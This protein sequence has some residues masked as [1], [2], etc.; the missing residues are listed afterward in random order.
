MKQTIEINGQPWA[1]GF[2]FKAIRNFETLSGKSITHCTSTWD[3]V[4]FFYSTLT[5][6]NKDFPL[7]FEQFTDYMDE[8]PMLLAEF[9]T[10]DL[11]PE[12]NIQNPESN[13][14]HPDQKKN[15][16]GLWML[17]GLLF[18]SPVLLP[19]ISGITWIWLSLKL[20][21]KFIAKIGKKRGS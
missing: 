20:S 11:N 19:I 6:L 10:S 7:D 14:Q 9:T 3:N 21:L 17:T 12:S 15:L 18:L 1:V 5:A 2:S 8:H 13:I 16:F 4:M